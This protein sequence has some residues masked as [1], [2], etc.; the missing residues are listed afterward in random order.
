MQDAER[1]PEDVFQSFL[2]QK[3]FAAAEKNTCSLIV[4]YS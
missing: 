1:L 3:V 4:V 2:P